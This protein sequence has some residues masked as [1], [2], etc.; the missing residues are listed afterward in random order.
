MMNSMKKY[1]KKEML[2]MI[3]NKNIE[4]LEVWKY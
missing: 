3:K 1:K 2:R 4:V